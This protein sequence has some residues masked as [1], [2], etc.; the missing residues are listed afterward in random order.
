MEKPSE[1]D[2]TYKLLTQ[3]VKVRYNGQSGI[4]YTLS[5]RNAEDIASELDKQSK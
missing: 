3:L 4:I 5:I 2:E 1:K